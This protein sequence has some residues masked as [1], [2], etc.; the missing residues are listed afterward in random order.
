MINDLIYVYITWN[1]DI[2]RLSS[3]FTSKF[4]WLDN[5]VFCDNFDDAYLSFEEELH[6]Y[7]D[8]N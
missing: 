4:I 1:V 8:H 6:G 2:T 7:K 3:T 5:I